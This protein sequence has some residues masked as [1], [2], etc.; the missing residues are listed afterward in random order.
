MF[1][2]DQLVGFEVITAVIT[3]SV[4]FWVLTPLTFLK[5]IPPSFF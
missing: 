1:T 4:V 2:F 5:N 3:R